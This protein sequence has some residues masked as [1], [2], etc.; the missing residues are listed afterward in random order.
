MAERAHAYT[1]E[2]RSSHVAMISHP[3]IVT[4]LILTAV[5]GH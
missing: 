5:R 4:A 3:D 2:V 1:V